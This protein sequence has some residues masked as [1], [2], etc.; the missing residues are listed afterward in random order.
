MQF[1]L[2]DALTSGTCKYVAGGTCGTPTTVNVSTV[3]GVFTVPIGDGT[4]TNTFGDELFDDEASLYLEVQIAGETLT[5]RR[6]LT[7]AAYAMHAAD[8][9]LLD[10]LNSDNDGCTAG[11]IVAGDANGNV[12]VTGAPQS[13]LAAGS[14]LYI[15]P[16]TPASDESIFGVANNGTAIFKI[17]E[18]GDIVRIGSSTVTDTVDQTTS[19]ITN[20]SATTNDVMVISATGLTSGDALQITT[21]AGDSAINVA[22]GDVTFND[23]LTVT[24]LTMLAQLRILHLVMATYLLTTHLKSMVCLEQMAMLIWEMQPV[25]RLQL[26]VALTLV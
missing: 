21:G 9:A 17:D 12:V 8:S 25:T 18:D 24:G 2:Y 7:S 16:A 26:L 13:S 23:N 20:N 6:Q 1:T 15:N 3:D 22:V 11:C 10:S 5:P 14:V 19:T 4:L